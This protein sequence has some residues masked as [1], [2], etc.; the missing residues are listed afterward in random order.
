[1]ARQVIHGGLGGPHGLLPLVGGMVAGAGGRMAKARCLIDTGADGVYLRTGLA[2][3]AGLVVTGSMG[4]D[5][6]LGIFQSR[7][8]AGVLRLPCSEG[9]PMDLAFVGTDLPSMPAICDVLVGMSVL[10]RLSMRF[11]PGGAFELALEMPDG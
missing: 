10:R 7:T 4:V 3:E 6:P 5:T 8:Y 11:W 1:M 9:P 2:D